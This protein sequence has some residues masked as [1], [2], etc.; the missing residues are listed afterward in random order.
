[1]SDIYAVSNAGSQTRREFVQEAE[2]EKRD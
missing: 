1:M 2:R